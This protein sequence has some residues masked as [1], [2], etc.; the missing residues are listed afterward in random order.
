MKSNWKQ[1]KVGDLVEQVNNSISIIPTETYTLLGMSLEGRGLFIREN[2]KGSEIGSKSLNKLESGY[3]IYSRLFAWKGAFDFVRD[4]FE[5]L[6][7]SDEYPTFRVDDK[8]IDVKF[9][10]YY[11]N[12]AKTWKAVEQYCIGVTKASRNR[13]KEEFFLEFQI[14]LP[15]LSEQKRIVAKIESIKSKIEAIRKL[16]EEQEREIN[17]LRNSIFLELQNEY[18]SIPIGII[19]IEKTKQVEIIPEQMYKQV[20]VRL[21]HKGVV[22][23]GII[24]GSEIGSKQFLANTGDFIISKIDARNGAMGIIP[25]ELDGAIVTSDFPLFRC[26]EKVNPLFFHYFSNTY[27]F[28]NACKQASEG[29]TNRKRLK[30]DRFLDIKMPF[31]PKE[32]QDR[33]VGILEK[34]NN[35]MQIHKEQE[36]ELNELLPGLLDKAFKGEL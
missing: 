6:F 1:T 17:N 21:E 10:Y 36:K 18:Q 9:L 4:E 34:T 12:Q 24:E 29:T 32:E 5:G 28:D 15:P 30:L 27:Y 16:R 33:I 7:V 8:K 25:A 14:P 35:L 20:T 3:F 23:R 26:S 31:P 19:L 2:K 13:F 11:F 22:K